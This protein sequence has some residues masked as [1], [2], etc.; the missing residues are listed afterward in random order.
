[1]QLTHLATSLLPALLAGCFFRVP[2]PFY[3]IVS[4]LALLILLPQLAWQPLRSLH[5]TFP[6]LLTLVRENDKQ[7]FQ[8]IPTVDSN[9]SSTPK[10][11]SDHL[12]RASQGHSLPVASANLM[13]P[14]LPSDADFP[15]EVV[16][17][18]FVRTWP[19]IL[20]SGGLKRMGRTH[21]H[22]AVDVPGP[23]RG[24][25]GE[26]KSASDGRTPEDPSAAEIA[27][28]TDPID[29]DHDSASVGATEQPQVLS[30]SDAAKPEVISG[31][32][33]D[34]NV[35]IWV[36][37]RQS[38]E[39]GGMNWWRSANGV[40]L[41]EGDEQGIVP[42]KFVKRVVRRAW[43]SKEEEVIWLPDS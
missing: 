18:T 31:M 3:T 13:T 35:L 4:H 8:L 41:T 40:I 28:S 29:A 2:N 9:T 24:G 11:P 1:M 39:E 26:K 16:H 7:R 12:I 32:R 37:V 23:G 20:E 15:T 21:V 19:L 33:R 38:L 22:F 43:G 36:D 30:P 25:K 6:E 42:M 14:I 34:A 5:L 10:S 17:G 27:V